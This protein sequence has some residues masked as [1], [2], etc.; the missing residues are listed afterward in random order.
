M[1]I[2]NLLIALIQVY[3]LLIIIRVVIS[4]INIPRDNI[5]YEI[6]F[7]LTEPVLGAVRRQLS[8]FFPNMM[9]DFSPMI[10]IILLEI[11][12]NFIRAI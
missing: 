7:N 11:I 12:S 10:V 3:S 8:G 4:W 5:F 2:Q 6:L 1:F 9:I